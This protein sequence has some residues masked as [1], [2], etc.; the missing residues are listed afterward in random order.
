ML[1]SRIQDGRIQYLPFSLEAFPSKSL[2]FESLNQALPQRAPNP[3]HCWVQWD[4]QKSLEWG[5]SYWSFSNIYLICHSSLVSWSVI[6]LVLKSHVVL[7]LRDRILSEPLSKE[8]NIQVCSMPSSIFSLVVCLHEWSPVFPN[9]SSCLPV[10]PGY[11]RLAA[12]CL[13]N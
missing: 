11:K 10:F 7:M 5:L 3:G 1:P 2:I 12:L 4:L 8:R 9:N 13:E 6:R